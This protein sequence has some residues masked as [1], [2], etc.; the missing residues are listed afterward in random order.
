MSLDAT[1]VTQKYPLSLASSSVTD[2]KI[3]SAS[4]T[5]ARAPLYYLPPRFDF[6]LSYRLQ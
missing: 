4:I 3:E 1:F 5:R 2:A 6:A